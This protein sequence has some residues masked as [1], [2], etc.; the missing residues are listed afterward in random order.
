M[1]PN[2]QTLIRLLA[3]ELPPE[4][5]QSCLEHLDHCRHCRTRYAQLQAT[6]D[7]L[8]QWQVDPPARDLTAAILASAYR[9]TGKRRWAWAA[10]ALL[11]AAG[12]GLFAGLF[13]TP[14]S[15]R[16]TA[17]QSILPDEAVHAAGLDALAGQTVIF[18]P[19][20]SPADTNPEEPQ[21]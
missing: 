7:M 13:T 5:R 17:Q 1:C 19:L 11:I 6:W 8:G 21:L 12:A 2:E 16:P 20:F 4:P 14:P 18:T 9:S 15:H 10:A 3:D